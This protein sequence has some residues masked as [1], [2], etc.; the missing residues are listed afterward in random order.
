MDLETVK[1]I[2]AQY[3]GH[4]WQLRRASL[5][6]ASIDQFWQ[7]M[8]AADPNVALKEDPNEALW[9]SRRSLPDREAWELRRLSGSPFA[10]VVVLED[11]LSDD[12]REQTLRDTEHRMFDGSHPEPTSH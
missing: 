12:E 6:R 5:S 2:V 10:L 8:A 3:A 9:F 11:S 1:A 4:G 7:E